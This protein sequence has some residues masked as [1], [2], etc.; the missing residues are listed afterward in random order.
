VLVTAP[1]VVLFLAAQRAFLLSP[2]TRLP[3]YRV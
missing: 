2:Y 1:L 3:D